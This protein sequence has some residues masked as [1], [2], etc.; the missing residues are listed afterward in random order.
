MIKFIL[1]ALLFVSAFA[2]NGD[3]EFTKKYQVVVNNQ[4][5]YQEY[6]Q[7]GDQVTVH[8]T[9]KLLDGSKFDS[10]VD[11]NSPFK[12]QVGVGRVIKCWDEV[13]QKLTLQDS[14]T[15]ICPSDTAYGSRGAG[16][17]IPPNS[18]LQFE[19]QMISFGNHKSEL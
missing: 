14:V 8:Y 18:D 10:S 1:L 9:G 11:R 19:I 3:E 13:I 17:L 2:Y 4:G 7:K 12:F 5:T 6:P 16:G 15:V